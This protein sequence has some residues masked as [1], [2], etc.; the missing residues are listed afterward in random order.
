MDTR[1]V[2]IAAVIKADETAI[3]LPRAFF[4]RARP[5]NLD[6]VDLAIPSKLSLHMYVS[7][8]ST[9]QHATDMLI[10]RLNA[11]QACT[12]SASSVTVGAKLPTYKFV[13]AGSPLSNDPFP[14]PI[15]SS[16]GAL[17]S[18]HTIIKTQN[19]NI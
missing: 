7:T 13:V 6:R 10:T 17:G 18:L 15:S 14:R 19:S 9:K 16:D 2:R 5:H 11:Q 3:A 8:S 4:F 12:S 1:F